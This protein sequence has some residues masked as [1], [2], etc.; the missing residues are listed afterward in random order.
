MNIQAPYS[1]ARESWI[2]VNSDYP[3]LENTYSSQVSSAMFTLRAQ[4]YRMAFRRTRGKIR[5]NVGRIIRQ[6]ERVEHLTT[7]GAK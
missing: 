2:G 3:V 7:V 6:L 5:R 4:M 1:P